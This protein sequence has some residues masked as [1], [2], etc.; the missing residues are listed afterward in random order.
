MTKD[1]RISLAHTEESI[2][3]N[4]EIVFDYLIEKQALPLFLIA[5]SEKIENDVR[6]HL[7]WK[8]PLN[9]DNSLFGKYGPEVRKVI[10]DWFDKKGITKGQVNKFVEIIEH[11]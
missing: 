4:A 1:P 3:K 10:E 7:I 9:I 2:K 5:E 8:V 6:S 11:E